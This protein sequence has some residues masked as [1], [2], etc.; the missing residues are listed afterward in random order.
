VA[1]R[2]RLILLSWNID[3][4][5]QF[6]EPISKEVKARTLKLYEIPYDKRNWSWL[7]NS[8]RPAEPPAISRPTGMVRENMVSLSDT[9]REE[10]DVNAKRGQRRKEGPLRINLRMKR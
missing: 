1:S 3:L 9:D 6:A 2:S 5:F 7:L 10:L 4:I 8:N